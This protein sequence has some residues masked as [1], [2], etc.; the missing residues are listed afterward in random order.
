MVLQNSGNRRVLQGNDGSACTKV[1]WD[2]VHGRIQSE[3]E[4]VIPMVETLDI[5]GSNVKT[6]SD[7]ST[8]ALIFDVL[9]QIRSPVEEH[10]IYR[11]IE[12]PFDTQV[13]K[14]AFV[15]FLRATN[16]SEFANVGTVDVVVP[17]AS[18]EASPRGRTSNAGLITGLALAIA[19]IVLLV[20]T[21]IY[22]RRRSKRSDAEVHEMALMPLRD[23]DS[24]GYASEL[25][26]E[27]NEKYEVSTLGDPIPHSTP[28]RRRDSADL[29]TIGTQSLDYDFHNAYV[30]QK[31]ITESHLA[32]SLE[33]SD[34][35]KTQLANL[36]FDSEGNNVNPKE[37][38]FEVVAPAG[39]LGLILES[40][41]DDG[42]PTV[43]NVK[44]NSVLFN[45]VRVGDRLLCVDNVD[46]TKMRAN[47]VSQ[48]IASKRDQKGR[49]LSFARPK[50]FNN[51][52]LDIVSVFD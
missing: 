44:P 3:V 39:L 31:S 46:V 48:L 6:E 8:V 50:N 1:W 45:V 43:H 12:G 33:T 15:N 25:D 20:A 22:V 27:L 35:P 26:V 47:D 41:I 7:G 23:N 40:N 17:K 5:D 18:E 9:I 36:G 42:R 11:Y 14:Q 24:N 49:I 32:E 4:N 37:E 51:E 19:G 34:S 13:E 2:E 30:D 28:T 38:E 10:D 29:S 52:T 16:C 21:F